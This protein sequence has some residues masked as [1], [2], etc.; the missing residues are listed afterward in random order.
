MISTDG[1]SSIQSQYK[2]MALLKFRGERACY[3]YPIL[4]NPTPDQ[5]RIQRI[6]LRS[7]PTLVGGAGK[8]H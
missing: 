8:Q 4:L 6:R 2:L 5:F 1:T 7:Q 3:V